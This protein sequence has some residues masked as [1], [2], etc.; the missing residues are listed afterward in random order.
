MNK[1]VKITQDKEKPV[2]VEVIAA[3]IQ[4]ISQGIKKLRQGPLNDNALY[5]LIQHAAPTV[6]QRPVSKQQIKAVLAGIEALESEY[7]KKKKG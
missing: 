1:S 4:A 6:G 2:P 3:D 7:L 5:L